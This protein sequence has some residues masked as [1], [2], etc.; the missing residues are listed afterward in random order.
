MLAVFIIL[1]RN[2]EISYLGMQT[3]N[4]LITFRD[5]EYYYG[6]NGN[7]RVQFTIEV[8]NDHLQAVSDIAAVNLDSHRKF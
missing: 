7:F 3:S 5:I 1:C 4:T 8:V 2:D 6:T